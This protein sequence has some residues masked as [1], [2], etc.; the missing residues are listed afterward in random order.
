MAQSGHKHVT[1]EA[2]YVDDVAQSQPM[3]EVWPVCSPHAHAKILRRDA[4]EAR[5]MPGIS[6]VLL[7]ED[8]PGLN[9]VG[10]VRHDEILLADNEVFYH[11]HI[12]AL[13]V[14]ETPELCRAAAANVVVEYEPVPPIFTIEDA[15]DAGSFHSDPNYIRR[16]TVVAALDAAP[17]TLEGE[18]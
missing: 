15:I 12:V 3:L 2:I 13:V 1:G 17:M 16:G 4:A 7:A 9:D 14:G 8:V 5:Q 6:A 10:A 11:G 18:F